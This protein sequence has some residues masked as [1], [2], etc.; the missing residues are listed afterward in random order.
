MEEGGGEK[1]KVKGL[2]ERGKWTGWRR[3]EGARG[4]VGE[5]GGW[6]GCGEGRV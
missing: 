3:E 1:E 5:G 4:G 2:R 6:E